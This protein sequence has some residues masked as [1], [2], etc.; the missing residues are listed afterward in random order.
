MRPKPWT[1]QRSSATWTKG[2]A[3]AATSRGTSPATAPEGGGEGRQQPSPGAMP[4]VSK[5]AAT[6]PGEAKAVQGGPSRAVAAE[7]SSSRAVVAQ[8]SSSAPAVV[9]KGNSSV[10]VN[11]RASMDLAVGQDCS[12]VQ[13][14][15]AQGPELAS[16]AAVLQR[17]R[18][19]RAP[20]GC[21]PPRKDDQVLASTWKDPQKGSAMSQG[22]R[23][24]EEGPWIA[25]L[26]N[27]AMSLP[28]RPR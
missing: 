22:V 8:G 26:I 9:G 19:D 6:S 5:A 25:G 10:P 15:S 14:T 1:L 4:G 24:C 20:N 7:G 12:G 23:R 28:G 3:V 17:V 18:G 2:C 11:I 16:N 13:G 27:Q 21:V